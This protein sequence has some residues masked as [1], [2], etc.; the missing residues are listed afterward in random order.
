MDLKGAA[1][2]LR[3]VRDAAA[4]SL[5]DSKRRGALLDEARAIVGAEALLVRARGDSPSRAGNWFLIDLGGGRLLAALPPK[6]GRRFADWQE[7]F[8]LY[9][10][11]TL[12]PPATEIVEPLQ[13]RIDAVERE[14]ILAAL[15]RTNGNK[16]RTARLLGITRAGLYLKM[17]RHHIASAARAPAKAV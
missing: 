1:A 2:A 6:K 4:T 5:F 14:A 17:N 7:E 13:D 3:W 12:F 9:V 8:L 10:A 16:S 15:K 11:E